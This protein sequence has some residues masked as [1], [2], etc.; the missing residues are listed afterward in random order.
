MQDKCMSGMGL[1]GLKPEHNLVPK[2]RKLRNDPRTEPWPPT[3]ENEG[4][5][6]IAR[7]KT[8]MRSLKLR[9]ATTASSPCR[10]LP[11]RLA[12]FFRRRSLLVLVATRSADI[13]RP[14]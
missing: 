1:H 2:F 5:P 11:G 4:A 3:Q 14:I 12:R 13:A 10:Q 6:P 7:T 9:N 8:L